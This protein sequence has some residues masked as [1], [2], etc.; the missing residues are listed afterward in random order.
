MESFKKIARWYEHRLTTPEIERQ[1]AEVD[2]QLAA[3]KQ[4][5]GQLASAADAKIRA[6][7]AADAQLP[8]KLEP[9]YPAETQAELKKLRDELAQLEQTRPDVPAAMGVAEDTVADTAIC[10]RGNP[11]KLG[12]VVARHVPPAIQGVPAPAFSTGQSGRRELA[13]WIVDPRHPLTARVIVNRVWRWHFGRGLVGTTDNFGLL[14]EPPAQPELLDWLARRFVADGW[15]LKALHRQILNSS[16]YRQTSTPHA[17]TARLDPENRLLGRAGVQ[18]LAAEQVR[19]ALLVVSGQLDNARGGSLLKVKN[20]EFFFDHTSKDLTDYHSRRRSL[21]LPVVRNN[22]YDVFQLYDY[23]DA[24][25][26]SGDRA[27]TTVAP[28]ALLML[29]GELVVESAR[30]LADRLLGESDSDDERLRRMVLVAYARA[31]TDQ[32]IA[33]CREFL[34]KAET[35]L[36]PSVADATE[37]RRQA[38]QVL[39]QVT[40]AANEFIYVR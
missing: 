6:A 16:T 30:Q 36:G 1:Q 32:E 33:G 13:A 8:E 26:S 23:P 10:L 35:A 5:I 14:G 7:A 40:L 9:L 39:C 18:R 19:D 24:A 20:R 38:W 29:N 2:A 17:D 3:Q 31:A 22:L 21:Y 28:Q 25:I 12:D 4:A 27:T 11:Q 15:S 34:Q 37:R